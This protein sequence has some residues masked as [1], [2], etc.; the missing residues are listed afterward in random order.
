MGFQ[1][2]IIFNK[3]SFSHL[4]ALQN[5]LSLMN[6]FLPFSSHPVRQHNGQG[7]REWR[8]KLASSPLRE[9]WKDMKMVM[10]A[11]MMMMILD[12]LSNRL[13]LLWDQDG[14]VKTVFFSPIL[15]CPILYERKKER[16][17]KNLIIQWETSFFAVT[18]PHY[19]PQDLMGILTHVWEWRWKRRESKQWVRRFS[20][21][22]IKIFCFGKP[23]GLI[24]DV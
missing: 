3:A 16:K 19:P 14:W 22:R 17:K 1:C 10:M 23:W 21:R 4:R 20:Q 9:E 18:L 7:E 6:S 13:G 24:L 11:M 5:C 8:R 15:S 2:T 12:T